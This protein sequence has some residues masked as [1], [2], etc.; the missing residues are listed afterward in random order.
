MTS[1]QSTPSLS[2]AQV[3]ALLDKDVAELLAKFPFPPID[4]SNLQFTRDTR[5]AQPAVG[6]S[7]AVTRRTI[8]IPG[9]NGAPNVALRIHR[10]A[11]V[12][13]TLPCLVWIHG[14]GL[15]MGN[16]EQDDLRFD[17]WC[18]SHAMMAISIEYRMAP[19]HQYPAAIDDCYAALSW[20][21]A[22]ATAVGAMPDRI[23]IG[24]ASAGAGL[25]AALALMARDR[26]GPAITSQLLFYPMLD[27]RMTTLSSQW[28]VPIWPPS[29]NEFGWAAYL[30]DARGTSDVSPYGA[31][32]RATDV[33]GLPPTI[34]VVGALDGFLDEDLTYAQRMLQ[35][36][37]PVELHVYPGAPH[38]F[39]GLLPASN[40]AKRCMTDIH[41]W[42]TAHYA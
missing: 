7:D 30:G 17:R 34:I 41:R 10:R 8:K 2:P 27:D 12:E 29:S 21:T 3:E 19:E 32:A 33:S 28:E 20:I 6:L 11:N 40:V 15:V 37:V 18:Q 13:T 39:D 38:G 31:P 23:G 36:G 35:A 5:Y 42:I 14:G 25:A 24:G 16:A 9:P 4:A 22:N 1:A 26:G